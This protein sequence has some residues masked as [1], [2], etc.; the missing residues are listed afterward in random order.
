MPTRH[1]AGRLLAV[2]V[3]SLVVVIAT[4]APAGAATTPTR[5]KVTTTTAPRGPVLPKAWLLLDVDTGKVL[6]AHDE[7]TLRRPASTIK[8]LTALTAKRHLTP[9]S[10]VP[11]SKLAAGMPARNMGLKVGDSWP[12][13]DMMNAMIE[14]GRAHV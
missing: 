1:R 8:L 2:L 6:D 11:V 3:P 14:I 4:V 5:P 12:I 7:H 13:A 10:M 9:T